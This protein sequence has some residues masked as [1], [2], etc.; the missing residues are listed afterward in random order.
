MLYGDSGLLLS[1]A[2]DENGLMDEDIYKK[3]YLINYH[4]TKE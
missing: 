2:F 4:L 1:L 3:Y